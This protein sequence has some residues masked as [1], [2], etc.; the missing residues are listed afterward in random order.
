MNWNRIY[1]IMLILEL[2]NYMWLIGYLDLMIMM[3]L[4]K[5]CLGW[6]KYFML[7]IFLVFCSGFCKKIC[8]YLLVVLFGHY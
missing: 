3:L 5:M 7:E 4:L 6:I 8:F 1:L 2:W